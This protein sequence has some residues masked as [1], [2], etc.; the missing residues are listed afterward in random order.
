MFVALAG[1]Y[2]FDRNESTRAQAVLYPFSLTLTLLLECGL[3]I[4][5]G[6]WRMLS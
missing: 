4:T 1:V 6:L 5:W 2:L 3:A